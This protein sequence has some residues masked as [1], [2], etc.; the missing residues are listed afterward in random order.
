MT[1]PENIAIERVVETHSKESFILKDCVFANEELDIQDESIPLKY[2][3]GLVPLDC[4]D[5]ISRASRYNPRRLKENHRDDLMD[6]IGTY[7]LVYPLVCTLERGPDA[8]IPSKLYLIDGRHRYNGLLELDPELKKDLDEKRKLLMKDKETASISD[9]RPM[10][11][12]RDRSVKLIKEYH[13]R[14]ESIGRLVGAPMIPVKIY[15]NQGDIE[16]IGMAVFLNRG[17]K[18][19]AGGEQIEKI[20][21]ALREALNIEI[22]NATSSMQASEARA[23]E[24]VLRSQN[25]S[26]LRFV[27]LSQHVAA[28]MDDEESPWH[29]LIG[30]WQGEMTEQAEKT[31]RKPLTASNF[32]AFVEHFLDFTP[33]PIANEK[34]RDQEIADLNRLGGIFSATF[35]WPKDIPTRN[36]PYTATSVLCRTFVIRAVGAVLNERSTYNGRVFSAGPVDE[37]TWKSIQHDVVAL[38]AEF[39]GQARLRKDFESKKNRLASLPSESEERESLI[40]E[41]DQARG[42][43]WTLDTIIPVLRTRL[44]QVLGEKK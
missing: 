13:P 40:I 24:K 35:D 36:S 22:A 39:Q 9:P 37:D 26:D 5:D 12:P 17:Q 15:L 10:T 33:F 3:L 27:V 32:L 42:D 21:Q 20:A 14:N 11:Q 1:M 7:G 6:Q 38:Q 8:Q 23:V 41:I 44:S 18:R 19:L 25:T 2:A 31:R 30:R 29:P 16:R 28:I 34:R 4:I 43:L